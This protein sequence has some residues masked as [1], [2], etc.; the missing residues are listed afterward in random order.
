MSNRPLLVPTDHDVALPDDPL[1]DG[2]S[3][4]YLPADDPFHPLPVESPE[5]LIPAAPPIFGADEGWAWHDSAVIAVGQALPDGGE[6]YRLGVA[7]LYANVLTGEIDGTFLEIDRFDDV[8]AA[9]AAYHDVQAQIHAQGLLPFDLVDF[10]GALARTRA[11]ERGDPI[12]EWRALT[13]SEYA[14]YDALR[15]LATEPETTDPALADPT[16]AQALNAIGID[17]AGFDPEADPPPFI[18]PETGTAYWI[19]MFQ[20]D[21]GDPDNAVTS[22]LSLGR[23]P[24]T[25]AVEAQLA[26]VVPGDWNKAY[27]AAEYLLGVVERGGIER[28]FEA[29]EGMALAADQ[30]DLWERERGIP[31]EPDA[32]QDLADYTRDQWEIDL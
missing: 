24:D 21:K 17:A 16:A 18:D 31:L 11:V 14:A 10:G 30:R 7:E 9:A 23:D 8:D 5:P 26:P 22:I 2:N 27:G 12:P 4:D 6:Q 32:A 25:G 19:G 3:Y 13:D 29:A 20:T 15:T 1:F 28:A